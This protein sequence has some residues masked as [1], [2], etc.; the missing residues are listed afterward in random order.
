MKTR[1]TRRKIGN[2]MLWIG[3]IVGIYHNQIVH[4]LLT[5]TLQHRRTTPF[6]PLHVGMDNTS[7]NGHLRGQYRLTTDV[8]I[9]IRSCM[10]VGSVS[11]VLKI[12]INI[13]IK[14]SIYLKQHFAANWKLSPL[15]ERILPDYYNV[16]FKFNLVG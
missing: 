2:R 7:L 14:Y 12:L 16:F 11:A 6:I 13:E 5:L 4:L 3:H 8:H 9:S 15:E 10:L 1:I